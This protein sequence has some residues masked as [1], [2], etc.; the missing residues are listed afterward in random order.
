MGRV[1]LSSWHTWAAKRTAETAA[2]P[3]WA[4]CQISYDDDD[5]DLA[6]ERE[7]EEVEKSERE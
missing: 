4:I 5:D 6:R 2:E 3:T 1:G 7:G